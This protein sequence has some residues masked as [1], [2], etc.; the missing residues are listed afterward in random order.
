MTPNKYAYGYCIKCQHFAF[1]FKAYFNN[2]L[3]HNAY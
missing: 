1:V 2:C 3:M